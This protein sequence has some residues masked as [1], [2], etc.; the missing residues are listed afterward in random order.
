MDKSKRNNLLPS[1]T[2]IIVL[3]S[4]AVILIVLVLS[5]LFPNAAKN[6]KEATTEATTQEATVSEK[7]KLPMG[8]QEIDGATRYVRADGKIAKSQWVGDYYVGSTGAMYTC[9]IT[10]DGKYVGYDGLV[11]DSVG[12]TNSH[13]GL[14]SLKKT[15]EETISDYHGTWSIYV[16]D[17]GHNEFLLINNVQHFSASLIKLYCAGAAFEL[18]DEGKLERTDRIDSLMYQMISISDNDAFNLMVRQCDENYNAVNGCKV[19]QD[20]IDRE[21][22]TDTTI[23]TMLVPTEYPFPSSPGRNYTTVADCGKMLEKIYKKQLV[24]PKASDEFLELLLNQQHINKI[25]SGLPEGTKCAN[26]TGDTDDTQHDAAIVYSPGGDYIIVVM[27]SNCGAAIPNIQNIS[28][29]VYDY[30]NKT[31]SQ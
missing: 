11:N 1:D 2:K 31:T 28:S 25:P 14:N 4:L 24:S 18:M 29:I 5:I 21:G 3:G 22:F 30:F 13:S 20:F 27:S 12:I 15:L 7:E 19:I 8:W 26:K 17:I 23:T 10:P 16:K 9:A 6:G